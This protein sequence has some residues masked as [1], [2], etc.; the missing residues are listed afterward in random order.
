MIFESQSKKRW[1]TAL[2]IFI[3]T[4]VVAVSLII[5]SAISIFKNSSLTSDSKLSINKGYYVSAN[6]D[7]IQA[8]INKSSQKNSIRD[9]KDHG[10]SHRHHINRQIS[11][12]KPLDLLRDKKDRFY[13]TAFVVTD[14]DNSVNDLKNHIDDLDMVIP[15]YFELVPKKVQINEFVRNDIQSLLQEKHV[16]IAPRL[17]NTDQNGN[18]M[19]KEFI[20]LVK[21]AKNRVALENLIISTLQKYD[22]E[23]INIDIEE[24]STY[25]MSPYLDFLDELSA[26]M[27]KNNM[28]LTVDVPVNDEQYDYAEIG[29]VADLVFAMGYDEHYEGGQPGAIAGKAWFNSAMQDMIKSIPKNKIIVATGQ[30]AYDWNIDA[31]GD[32]NAL[33]FDDTVILATDVGADMRTDRDEINTTFSYKNKNNQSHSVW[34][35]DGISMWNEMQELNKIG[36]KGIGMWRMGLEDPSIWNFYGK[37]T[38]DIKPDI[39]QKTE[40]LKAVNFDGD[41]EIIKVTTTPKSGNRN[42]LQASDNTIASADYIT[43]PTGYTVQ[44]YGKA[45]S[46]KIVLTFDDGPDPV[47]TQQILDILK[48]YNVTA[49]FFVVGQQVLHNP[50]LIVEEAK[51]GDLIGDHTFY[52]P[53][54]PDITDERLELEL[55]TTQRL[56]QSLTGMK[57]IL[58]RSPYNTDTTNTDAA[59]LS[60][61]HYAETLGYIMIGAD[62]DSDDYDKPGVDRI[63]S[64]VEQGLK[65]TGSNIVVMHDAGGDRSQ[66][67]AALLRIIPDLKS[68]GYQFVNISDLLALPSTVLMPRLNM[69]E[70]ALVMSDKVITWIMIYGWDL[71]L[72]LFFITTI[73]SI[74]R[75]LFLGIFV[76][77]SHNMVHKYNGVEKFEP[78]VTVLIPA[79]NEETVIRKTINCVLSGNYKNLEILVI[80]DGSNDNTV[81]IIEQAAAEYTQV[82]LIKK[83]NGGKFSAL[84]VGFAQAKADYIVTIDAD[85]IILADT[86]RNLILPFSDAKVDAVC[87]NVQVGNVKNILTGFQTVEYI[88]T[89]NY[90]RRAFDSLNCIGVVPGATGAWKKS[91]V[92]EVGGYSGET[93]TEDADLTLTML[94]HGARII[95]MPLAKSVTEA[96]QTMKSLFKQ[97]FR[98]AFGTMQTMWK[99]HKSFFKGTLGKVA[100]PN[101]FIFQV[102]FPI[103]APIGDLVFILSIIKGDINAILSGYILFLFMDLV[104]SLIAFTLEKAPMKYLFLVLI[105]RFF[106]R[107]FM[108]IITFKSILAVLKGRKHSWNKLK[109]T[110]SVME[111]IRK[112]N[113]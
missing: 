9:N 12:H 28:Y 111:P 10:V 90:D 47:F 43:L 97:R 4:I 15:D 72:V 20:D 98:W 41:G 104:G 89:Q 62:V 92:Q 110:N 56:I 46:N 113:G 71:I 24:I 45:N 83:R 21:N 1:K 70:E 37:D 29:Q 73:V 87:G 35:L 7:K 51:N 102:L 14:D 17:A 53:N 27:H 75:I 61:I 3:A 2:V 6:L 79:Y 42:I 84:N 30:Y 106:Y 8:L 31:S 74:V 81:K 16:M 100:L 5:L 34:L 103:L 108:Y 112:T 65:N 109:R 107:Q 99:H 50:E 85:T 39:L 86:I 82:R 19:G 55:N 67:V 32:A 52:H 96:P 33:S 59:T 40:T 49:T 95:Y 101:I 22:L 94:E 38:S 91:K 80:D 105:Q 58:W 26:L 25:D 76:L 66:T 78:F 18:W 63:V 48:K 44:K 77:R 57:T 64:N 68:Q 36:I 13:R 88:T 93:L 23:A 69:G 11:Q 60:S 54:L